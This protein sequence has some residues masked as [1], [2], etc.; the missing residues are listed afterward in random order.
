MSFKWPSFGRKGWQVSP[1]YAIT[2]R[3]IVHPAIFRMIKGD[4]Q[5]VDLES[6]H[7]RDFLSSGISKVFKAAEIRRVK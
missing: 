3:N 6:M 2:K 5:C 7:I 4:M 1:E